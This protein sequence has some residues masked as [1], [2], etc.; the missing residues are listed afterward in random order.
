MKKGNER[1]I[2]KKLEMKDLTELEKVQ[3][4]AKQLRM[5]HHKSIV[6]YEDEFLHMVDGP[7]RP[8]YVY[9]ILMEYCSCGDLTDLIRETGAGLP[10]N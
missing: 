9:I 1:Y 6:S 5:L 7:F 3:Y 2:L 8:H 10:E 4:E